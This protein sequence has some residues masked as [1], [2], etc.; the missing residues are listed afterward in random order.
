[1]SEAASTSV[2][3]QGRN[4]L[5]QKQQTGAL[6]AQF[7][8]PSAIAFDRAGNLLIADTSNNRIRK[9]SA[10]YLTVTTVAGSGVQGLKDGAASEAQFDAPVGLAVDAQ[11]NVYVA[12]TY[13][14]CIRKI[15]PDGQVITLAGIGVPGFQD[16]NSTAAM[17][18]TQGEA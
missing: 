15:T 14:D 1:M 4:G 16:G 8:T 13:N 2:Y 10:D 18:D 12:D 7:N 5:A 3:S 6:E 11:S 9:L 17:F